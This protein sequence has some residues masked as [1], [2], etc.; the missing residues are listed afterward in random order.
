M[1]KI[2]QS[3]GF[4]TQRKSKCRHKA[5]FV[6]ERPIFDDERETQPFIISLVQVVTI[7]LWMII[8][9]LLSVINQKK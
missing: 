4:I 8:T 3:N 1:N 5:N 6:D 2:V 9:R 7:I